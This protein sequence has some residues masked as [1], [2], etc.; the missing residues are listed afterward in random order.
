MV[1]ANRVIEPSL[2]A[3]PDSSSGIKDPLMETGVTQDPQAHRW[4]GKG[5]RRARHRVRK[6][7][8]IRRADAGVVVETTD[9]GCQ[10][11]DA[12]GQ[13]QGAANQATPAMGD[14]HVAPGGK[15]LVQAADHPGTRP[16]PGRTLAGRAV[17]GRST[18]KLEGA[19]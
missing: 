7:G 16:C 10:T 8:G 19:A 14:R 13:T 15:D 18:G 11:H 9:A 4:Q 3:F 2:A 5:A 12:G 17:A 6:P 1:P